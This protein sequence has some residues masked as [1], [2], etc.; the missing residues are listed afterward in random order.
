MTIQLENICKSVSGQQILKDI[1]WQIASE[2]CWLLTGPSG[3]GKTMLLRL[4]LGLE[5]PD[6]GS[7]NL[8]GDYKYANVNAGVVFQ[9]DR[10]C[11]QFSAVENVAMVNER[12]SE[13]VAAE[14]LSRFLPQDRQTVPVCELNETERRLVVMIRACI[15]PSDILLLDEPFRGMDSDL[16]SRAITYIR[17]KAGHKGIVFVQR[18][19]SGL[20]FCR[21]FPL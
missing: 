11:E 17:D 1:N 4:I 2:D 15:I 19:E 8:L 5:K 6:S 20:E 13:T 3:S 7:V 9:E 14:E 12:L 21:K 10:L 16:R 18:D